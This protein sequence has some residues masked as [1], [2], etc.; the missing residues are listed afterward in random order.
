MQDCQ[1]WFKHHATMEASTKFIVTCY[2]I[3]RNRNEQIFQNMQADTWN[4]INII[5]FYHA[6]MV[7]TLCTTS[8]H[9]VAHQV[10]WNLPPEDYIKINVDDSSFGNPENAGFDVL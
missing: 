8:K 1:L 5:V 2:E 7:Y 10:R 3:W 4:S 6:S 9:H